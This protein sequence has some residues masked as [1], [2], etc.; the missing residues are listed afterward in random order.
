VGRRSSPWL[1]RLLFLVL[2]FAVYGLSATFE[3]YYRSQA[4]PPPVRVTPA[5]SVSPST[6]G[7]LSQDIV[8]GTLLTPEISSSPVVAMHIPAIGLTLRVEQVS[9]GSVINP[10]FDPATINSLVY[11]DSSRGSNPGTDATNATYFAGHTWR[12]SH[13]AFNVIDTSLRVNDDVYVMT[14]ESERLG[15]WM[16]YVVTWQ[17]LYRKSSL[18]NPNNSLWQVEPRL[19]FITCHL[20]EDGAEQTDNRVFYADLVGVSRL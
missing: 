14:E 8:P 5:Q 4:A 11:Q 15:V 19:V 7:L 13:A 6:G 12:A 16:H 20:R 10:P 1:S 18:A 2:L 3:E 9:F 17:H